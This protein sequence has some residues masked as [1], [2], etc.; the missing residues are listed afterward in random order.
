[1]LAESFVQ[2]WCIVGESTVTNILVSHSYNI[3]IL[4]DTPNISQNDVGDHGLFVRVLLGFPRTL[5]RPSPASY[6]LVRSFQMR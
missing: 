5:E 3:A 1:M 6:V 2:G 4:S